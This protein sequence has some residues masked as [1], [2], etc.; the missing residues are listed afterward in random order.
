MTM[1]AAVGT[2]FGLFAA[3]DLPSST[4]FE[5]DADFTDGKLIVGE[6]TKWTCADYDAATLGQTQYEPS[7]AYPYSGTARYASFGSDQAKYLTIKTAFD[8]PL[9]R[10]FTEA[11]AA[12]KAP[13]FIDQLVKF[14]AADEDMEIADASAKIGVWAKETY[15]ADGETVAGVNLFVTAGPVVDSKPTIYDL[16]EIDVEAWHRLTIKAIK[17]KNSELGYEIFLDGIALE[18]DKAGYASAEGLSIEAQALNAAKKI[19]P[20]MVS[21][22]EVASLGIAGQGA[23]DDMMATMTSPG[24]WA[25]DKMIKFGYT[26][27]FTKIV[28]TVH[29]A[30]S[31]IDNI[32]EAGFV[33]IPYASG[34]EITIDTAAT[35]LKQDYIIKGVSGTGAI[36][37]NGVITVAENADFV[38]EGKDNAQRIQIGD[39]F[40]ANFADAIAAI[41]AGTAANLVLK[42]DIEVGKNGAM[43][44]ANF[45]GKGD[46]TIDLN[47]QTIT[48]TATLPTGFVINC[49]GNLTIMNSKSTGGIAIG[50]DATYAGVVQVVS[51][52]MTAR[53]LTVNGGQF[54]G[55]VNLEAGEESER[56]AATASILCGQFLKAANK[57]D[58]DKFTLAEFV[59]E[60]SDLTDNGTY[61]LVT[62]APKCTVSF[63]DGDTEYEDL[64][65][66]VKSGSKVTQPADPVKDYYTFKAWQ[67][68]GEDFDFDTSIVADTK[69]YATW[70][71]IEYT[72]S[73]MEGEG[74]DSASEFSNETYTV[75]TRLTQV[76]W[77]GTRDG[78]TFDGWYD[79]EGNDV[80]NNTFLADKAA[81]VA[82]YG[83][84]TE[85][86]KDVTITLPDVKDVPGVTAITAYQ[87]DDEGATWTEV[88][89]GKIV[90]GKLWKVEA[91]AANGYK[92]E[93]PIKSGTAEEGED[94]EITTADFEGKV[95]PAVVSVTVDEVTK[96]YFTADEA[97]AAVEDYTKAHPEDTVI[98]SFLKDVTKENAY[99]FAAGTSV[100]IY[101]NCGDVPA[102]DPLSTFWDVEGGNV[103]FLTGLENNKKVSFDATNS[104]DEG[105]PFTLTFAGVMKAGS[106]IMTDNLTAAAKA[107]TLDPTDC[108]VAVEGDTSEHL[109]KF[110]EVPGYKVTF[111]VGEGAFEGYVIYSL[112]ALPETCTLTVP[113]CAHAT[114]TVKYDGITDTTNGVY[115][116]AY[117]TDYLVKYT[118]DEGYSLSGQVSASGNLTEDTELHAPTAKAIEYTITFVTENP[119]T[120]A[121]D[122]VTYTVNT[123][124]PLAIEDATVNGS[125]LSIEFAGWTNET[126][127]AAFKG[128]IQESQLPT[129][130]ASFTLYAKWDVVIPKSEGEE[131]AK[132]LTGTPAEQAEAAEA[133][134]E[135]CGKT[136][137]KAADVNTWLNTFG[138]K[139]TAAEIAAAKSLDVS[140]QLG[141][142]TLFTEEPK[143]EIKTF[144]QAD[145]AATGNVGYNMTFE[146][147][148]GTTAT[149]A[150]TDAVKA[151]IA[152]LVQANESVDFAGTKITVEPTVTVSGTTI[153]AK[154]EIPS[155]K[156][157]AFMKV[158]TSAAE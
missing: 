123:E 10:S 23:I 151:Y 95:L 133:I 4:S 124:F 100:E 55:K 82:I 79:A 93:N 110:A 130:R 76:L 120:T 74:P 1:I 122:P 62:V 143:A 18:A 135:M 98:V 57:T 117:G 32:T 70:T 21:G 42:K 84:W 92:V 40:Y 51:P 14:T 97:L 17:A 45:S 44:E 144:A 104:A 28:Y 118:A 81:N 146:I 38:L 11:G 12:D 50:E 138:T 68:A 8:K 101:T 61:F 103:S 7:E 3:T 89:D 66:T 19:F 140:Y 114:V 152:T 36:Y 102:G 105:N 20:A 83:T 46:I 96:Y 107:I 24:E 39:N 136:L 37:D 154:V 72:I 119:N 67:N 56:A 65:A 131:V 60:G 145:T 106:Y 13:V 49:L 111:A 116:L 87:S 129:P 26:A 147:A 149:P 31:T 69:L 125:T 99:A 53:K 75:E 88:E 127:T 59:D 73:Y 142:A 47:G 128:Q 16:G 29:G 139:P 5:S 48:G 30:Q 156:A 90:V 15:E 94:I 121:P 58:D 25:E 150:D 54:D 148:G 115:T 9:N 6:G 108:Y 22:L 52:D 112:E 77:D 78:F 153:S 63:W 113:E 85:E 132:D 71:A 157:A 126:I 64:R 2:A 80:D 27:D 35:T 34:M 155:G 41:P 141:A 134:D 91:T 33:S 109:D 43:T 137:A 158:E 86:V